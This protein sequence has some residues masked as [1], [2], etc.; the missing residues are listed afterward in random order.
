MTKIKQEKPFKEYLAEIEKPEYD[1]ADA[2][3]GLPENPT[4]LEKAKYELCQK[5][6]GYQQDN[7]LSDK[8]IAQKIHLTT[9][10][11]RDILYC[12]I[13]YFTLD[14]LITYAGRL[15]SPSQVKVIIEPE[16]DTIH[17]RTV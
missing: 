2:S 5:I 10:E 14:R 8:E 16:K 7:N 15:F 4:P 9:G 6:L 1:D 17:A 12:H 3:W 13:D 11:T